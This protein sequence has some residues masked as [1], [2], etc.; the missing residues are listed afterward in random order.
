MAGLGRAERHRSCPQIIES[1]YYVIERAEKI[2]RKYKQNIRSGS[3]NKKLVDEIDK[4]FSIPPSVIDKRK[5]LEKYLLVS[6]H[7][8]ETYRKLLKMGIRPRDAIFIIPRAVKN[9]IL[10]EFDLYNFELYKV[11][12]YD[13]DKFIN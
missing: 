1:I 5:L 10:Q 12:S 2:F 13:R 8:F 4:I 11:L 7:S 9:D 3:I 6:L